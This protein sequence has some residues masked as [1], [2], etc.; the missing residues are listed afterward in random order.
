MRTTSGVAGKMRH[1]ANSGAN[2]NTFVKVL[3]F[4]SAGVM[5][6]ARAGGPPSSASAERAQPSSDS[7]SI[8]ASPSADAGA[9]RPST[10]VESPTEA[11]PG[12]NSSTTKT[13][14]RI[15]LEDKTLTNDEVRALFA[16][17]YKPTSR[18]GEVYYCRKEQTTGSRFADVICRSAAQ[19]KQ[20]MRDAKDLLS[21]KQ[22]PGGC[23]ANGPTC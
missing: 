23:M 15:E 3:A 14:K 17:G 8:S 11:Q 10:T 2:V 12:A 4:V 21:A 13:T 6:Q 18:N 7:S 1:R 22:K 5:L 16:Q 19:M 20:M 9:S